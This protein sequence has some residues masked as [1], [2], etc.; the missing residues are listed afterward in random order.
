VSY[1]VIFITLR[2]QN[3]CLQH[4]HKRVDAAVMTLTNGIFNNRVT[5]TGPHIVNVSL[6]FVDVRDLDMMDSLLIS[7]K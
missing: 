4:D 7:V 1:H 3:V 5:E 2:A 6:Q